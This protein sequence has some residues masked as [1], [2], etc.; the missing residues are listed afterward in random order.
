VIPLLLKLFCFIT[1][2]IAR[3][4][5][6]IA[7]NQAVSDGSF[8]FAGPETFGADIDLFRGSVYNNFYLL[9]I[10][11]P[12]SVGPY[13]RVTVLFTERHFLITYFTFSHFIASSLM[14]ISYYNK[15]VNKGQEGIKIRL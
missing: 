5:S 10:R 8:Y 11:L 13:M 15:G 4:Q 12:S 1:V 7:K 9:Y 2:P 6:L 3:R 14:C